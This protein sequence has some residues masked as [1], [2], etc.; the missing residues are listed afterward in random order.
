[1]N[2]YLCL[3]SCSKRYQCNKVSNEYQ[4][5]LF[6]QHLVNL[7]LDFPGSSQPGRSLGNGSSSHLLSSTFLPFNTSVPLQLMNVDL[8]GNHYNMNKN[9]TLFQLWSTSNNCINKYLHTRSPNTCKTAE[10]GGVGS[11]LRHRHQG[12][13]DLHHCH[14]WHHTKHNAPQPKQ[15]KV[16]PSLASL[17]PGKHILTGLRLMWVIFQHHLFRFRLSRVG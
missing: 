14:Y 1:M 9:Q 10:G 2:V 7:A 4:H 17:D 6:S 8:R 13:D 3:L 11:D 12:S 16:Y 15:T 5:L